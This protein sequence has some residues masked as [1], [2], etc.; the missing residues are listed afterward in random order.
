MTIAPFSSNLPRYLRVK[1]KAGKPIEKCIRSIVVLRIVF[2][3][4]DDTVIVD[5]FRMLK[6][7]EEVRHLGKEFRLIFVIDLPAKPTWHNRK[8]EASNL[9]SFS[10][11]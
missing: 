1:S 5:A 4:L 6:I 8:R 7:A 2:F 3:E 10:V 9:E 11:A